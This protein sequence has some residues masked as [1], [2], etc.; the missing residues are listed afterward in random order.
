MLALGL[1][2]AEL[3]LRRARWPLRSRAIL[4]ILVAG[5]L[6]GT[7]SH[8]ADFLRA[9]WLPYPE[10]P[11]AF[12]AFWTALL[13]LDPL[14]AILLVRKTRAGLVMVVLI[15]AA[16]ISVNLMAFGG[17]G[18]FSPPNTALLFQ[19]GFGAMAFVAAPAL[20]HR[21]GLASPP[22]EKGVRRVGS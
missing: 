1:P 16:D 14:G 11:M 5:L 19:L 15:M 22:L 18:I 7:V 21:A 12:N 9:G 20:W 4:L 3:H 6:V 10:Q 17:Q 2:L 8:S 13:F